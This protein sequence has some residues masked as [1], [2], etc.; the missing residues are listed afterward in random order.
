M[1]SHWKMIIN[2]E[3]NLR[4][5]WYR[6]LDVVHLSLT[7]IQCHLYFVNLF[8]TV[9]TLWM[10]KLLNHCK[11]SCNTLYVWKTVVTFWM[12]ELLH[13]CLYSAIF[14]MLY[15]LLNQLWHFV[16]SNT[17][18]KTVML[19]D[20]KMELEKTMVTLTLVCSFSISVTAFK[21]IKYIFILKE[22][23]NLHFNKPEFSV[24]KYMLCAI[25]FLNW[26]SGSEEKN[27]KRKKF[28]DGQTDRRSPDKM[29]L[30]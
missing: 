5:L 27:Q 22:G 11:N 7:S 3:G 16:Y 1:L 30:K 24:T 21:I 13:Y 14:C 19:N 25:F 17:N 8:K 15:K 18:V 28:S 2:T 23:V 12:F 6:I 4:Q 9:M 20:Q 10:L 26:S 29:W